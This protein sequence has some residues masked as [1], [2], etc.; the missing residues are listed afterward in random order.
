LILFSSPHIF[1]TRRSSDL[2][3]ALVGEIPCF[4]VCARTADRDDADFVIAISDE[5]RPCFLANTAD[6]LM[7]GFVATPSRNLEPFGIAPNLLR[8][9]EA[10]PVLRLV[11]GRLLRI[12]LKRE[13]YQV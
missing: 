7:T 8:F 9:N 10:D 12:K 3:S 5:S 2:L 6:H 11:R 13:R 4:F 1:P